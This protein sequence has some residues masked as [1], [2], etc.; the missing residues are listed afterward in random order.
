MLVVPGWQTLRGGAP[1]AS[2]CLQLINAHAC[3]TPC[4]LSPAV[5]WR[6]PV[7]RDGRGGGSHGCRPRRRLVAQPVSSERTACRSVLGHASSLLPMHPAA[8]AH[9]RRAW[10]GPSIERLPAC[11]SPL[12]LVQ[13]RPGV[14]LRRLPSARRQRSGRA[15]PLVCGPAGAPPGKPQHGGLLWSRCTFRRCHCSCLVLHASD[16]RWLLCC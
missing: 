13:P 5:C 3:R 12:P 7:G 15:R 2:C 11:P 6:Q 1:L 4:A 16:C 14:F 9:A 10:P 8:L